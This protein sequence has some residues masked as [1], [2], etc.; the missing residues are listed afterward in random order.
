M[1]LSLNS[2]I[3]EMGVMIKTEG[4]WLSQVRAWHWEMATGATGTVLF[5]ISALS[6]SPSP[7]LLRSTQRPRLRWK[8]QTRPGVPASQGQRFQPS[9]PPKRD[10]GGTQA[11]L[12][13]AGFQAWSIPDLSAETSPHQGTRPSPSKTGPDPR[14]ARPGQGRSS[15]PVQSLKV[16]Q[17]ERLSPGG[18]G[19][20]C[21]V[22]FPACHQ[23]G[24]PE[25]SQGS[26]SFRVRPWEEAASPG[27]GVPGDLPPGNWGSTCL[28]NWLGPAVGRVQ[29]GPDLIRGRG[30]GGE[31]AQTEERGFEMGEGTPALPP[32]PT[33]ITGPRALGCN[34]VLR[35]AWL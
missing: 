35:P 1:C 5:P 6:Y 32:S 26:A 22:A 19:G 14:T 8:L 9:A 17:P 24:R 25:V 11:Q 21:G 34:S 27:P 10:E 18:G 12:E 29:L 15:L 28:A 20:Q 13:P 4:H 16:H 3:Y 33:A 7:G 2:L 23:R 30:Q 31:G